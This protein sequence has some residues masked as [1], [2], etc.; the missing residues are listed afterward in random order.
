MQKGILDLSY[1]LNMVLLELVGSPLLRVFLFVIHFAL[2][3]NNQPT[4]SL[5]QPLSL[6]QVP[7]GNL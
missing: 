1:R 5:D 2:L 3:A 6:D 7:V 4:Q